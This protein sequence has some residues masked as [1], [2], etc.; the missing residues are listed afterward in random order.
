MASSLTYGHQA[1]FRL[2][3]PG[4]VDIVEDRD[5]NLQHVATLQNMIEKLSVVFAQLP[6]QD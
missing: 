2:V 1:G 4:V 5:D 6:E 3:H